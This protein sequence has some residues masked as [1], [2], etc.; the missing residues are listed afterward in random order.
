MIKVSPEENESF[1]RLL[2]RFKRKVLSSKLM[3]EIEENRFFMSKS[4]KRRSKKKL[5]KKRKQRITVE[6]E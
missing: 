1:D 2:T 4:E 3:K 5:S 6:N